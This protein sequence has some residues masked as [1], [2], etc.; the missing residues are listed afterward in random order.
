MFCL[1]QQLKASIYLHWALSEDIESQRKGFVA[2]L[3]WPSNTIPL[4]KGLPGPGDK[5]FILSSKFLASLPWRMIAF[6][7]CFPDKPMFHLLRSGIFLTMGE[8]RSRIRM[9]VGML[10]NS[11]IDIFATVISPLIKSLT[12]SALIQHW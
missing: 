8:K 10:T 3:C 5:E 4:P 7:M 1:L 6:H 11:V 12:C 2:I 9:H